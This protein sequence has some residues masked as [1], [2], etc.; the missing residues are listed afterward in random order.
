MKKKVGELKKGDHFLLPGFYHRPKRPHGYFH[1][2]VRLHY[3]KDRKDVVI[4]ELPD[5]VL[6]KEIKRTLS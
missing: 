2:V 1:T 4:I 6:T 3:L 5:K